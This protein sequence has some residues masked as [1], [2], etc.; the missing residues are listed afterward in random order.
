VRHLE[1]A[2]AVYEESSLVGHNDPATG[3]YA[4]HMD[5][6][7]MT[8]QWRSLVGRVTSAFS[9]RRIVVGVILIWLITDAI[10]HSPTDGSCC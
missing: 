1:T 10:F 3:N 6:S 5:E 2:E 4:L 8:E 7:S 9:T